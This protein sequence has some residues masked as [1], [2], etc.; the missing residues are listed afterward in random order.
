M[1]QLCHHT[2]ALFMHR[3][4]DAGPSFNLFLIINSRG[5]TVPTPI[6]TR[7][8]TFGNDQPG[9]STLAV[10]IHHNVGR[11][12]ILTRATARHGC[13]HNTVAQFQRTKLYWCK[14]IHDDPLTRSCFKFKVSV[15][16]CIKPP[17]LPLHENQ[18][19][20]PPPANGPTFPAA[21]WHYPR[22]S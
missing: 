14:Q 19:C 6:R 7:S 12:T 18:G 11:Q 13:H 17:L 20:R 15:V 4:G 22:R 2:T 16:K 9:G 1:H 21:D 5:T 3:I 8:D 10:I